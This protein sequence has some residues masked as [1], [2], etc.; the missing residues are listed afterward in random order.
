VDE[1]DEISYQPPEP[2]DIARRAL[3][4]S[5]VVCRA[6]IESYTD[7]EY[8]RETADDIHEWF[9]ELD[10]WPYLEPDEEQIIR[11]PF[12]EMPRGAEIQGTWYVEGL[13]VLA[14]ALRR[15]EFPPHDQ[16]VDAIAV[17]NALQF[18]DPDAET[19]LISPTVRDQAEPQAAREWFYDLHCKLGGFLRHGG[20]GR[21][22]SWI[23][24]YL[25]IL[26]IDPK[27]VMHDGRLTVD[28]KPVGEANRRRLE[29]WESVIRERH[30][31][32]IWLVGEQPLYTELSVDL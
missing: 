21:L 11:S 12:G 19:L 29:E 23:G 2:I 28:G 5:G 16:K 26:G 8:K 31:A 18:L 13:A 15:G 17:T 24:D 4:L 6:S 1:P 7:E 9:D 10:L 20:D 27:L 32:T 25:A 3:I 14:W 30:R 22:A